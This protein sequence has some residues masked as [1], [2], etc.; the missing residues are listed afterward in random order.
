MRFR[1]K[2]HQ[3]VALALFA[4]ARAV[5]SFRPAPV[6]MQRWKPL[7]VPIQ[8]KI[9]AVRT[10]EFTAGLDTDYRLFVESERRIEFDR[11]EGL[12]GMADSRQSK[13]CTTVPEVI[14]IDWKV[15]HADKVVAAGSS[16]SSKGGF[17]GDTVAREI[18]HFSAQKGQPY[19]VVLDVQRDGGELTATN[20]K[21]L[22]QTYPGAWKDAVVGLA[23]SSMLRGIGIAVC[24]TAGLLTLILTP[25][26]GWLHRLH[27][28]RHRLPIQ[29]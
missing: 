15:L 9:G 13:T 6:D 7:V 26:L 3:Y 27:Q 29:S 17:Y 11:L 14:D 1:P 21:L 24:A 10:T 4:L 12:L 28:R 20:P 25:L 2:P 22:V 5:Y 16:Q 18:G 8:L 23:L 19:S